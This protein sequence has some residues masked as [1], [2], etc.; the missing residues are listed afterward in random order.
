VTDRRTD[1]Q[2]YDSQ[3][4]AGIARAVKTFSRWS[5]NS[6]HVSGFINVSV[7]FV[8]VAWYKKKQNPTSSE[9]AVRSWSRGIMVGKIYERGR[10]WA[11]SEERG[12]YGWWEWWVNSVRRCGRRWK[13]QVRDRQLE[14]GRCREVGSWFHRRGCARVWTTAIKEHYLVVVIAVQ[15]LTAINAVYSFDNMHVLRCS[16]RVRSMSSIAQWARSLG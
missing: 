7:N 8:N 10:S 15:S 3:D 16:P 6:G 2:N 1:W 11:G 4:R 5:K 9:E 13:W 14:L 12:S